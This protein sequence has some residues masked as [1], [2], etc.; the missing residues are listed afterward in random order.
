MEPLDGN[1]IGGALLEHFGTEMTTA[2][3]RCVHCGATSQIAE[4][5]V[6][7]RAPGTV[8]RCRHCGGVVIVIVTIRETTMVHL[9]GFELGG[10]PAPVT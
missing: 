10:G 3:G 5:Q 1:A 2:A 8:V 9:G 6:Y 7:L 4:L